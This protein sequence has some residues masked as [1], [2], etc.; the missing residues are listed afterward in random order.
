MGIFDKMKDVANMVTGGAAR[1]S[2]EY[3]PQ[4]AFPGEELSVRVIATSTGGQV[5]SK[6]VFVDLQSVE[7]VNMPRGTMAGQE[8]A[9]N[10]SYTSFSKEV[11]I[12]PAFTLEPNETREFEGRVRLP[13]DAQ[14]TFTG[15]YARHEWSIRGRVEATGN[16]PDSGYQSLRV[17]S[18]G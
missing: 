1:V 16:D 12:S 10:T 11:Q 3:E 17:G 4:Q 6:G 7:R 2:I 14:P 18:N 9:V 8:N 15:R 5:K 13:P